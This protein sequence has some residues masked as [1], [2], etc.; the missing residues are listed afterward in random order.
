MEYAEEG[1]LSYHIKLR[2]EKNEKF[3]ENLIKNWFI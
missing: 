1:D 3:S 2:K